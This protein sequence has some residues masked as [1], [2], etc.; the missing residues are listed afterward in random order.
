MCLHSFEWKQQPFGCVPSL[1]PLSLLPFPLLLSSS[2]LLSPF[3]SHFIMPSRS[4]SLP[5]LSLSFFSYFTS[6]IYW[7]IRWILN[8][9]SIVFLVLPSTVTD[10]SSFVLHTPPPLPLSPSLSLPPSLSPS[11]DPSCSLLSLFVDLSSWY[12]LCLIPSILLFNQ[13]IHLGWHHIHSSN[14]FVRTFY[15]F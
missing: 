7:I 1:F 11:F 14:G 10:I 6:F 4:L 12:S 9:I 15:W 13:M 3:R 8:V 5:L 2:F